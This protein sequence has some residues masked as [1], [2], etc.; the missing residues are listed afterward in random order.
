MLCWYI[1]HREKSRLLLSQIR[2]FD[3]AQLRR[4]Y[5]LRKRRLLAYAFEVW[6]SGSNFDVDDSRD[7]I[8]P[9][10]FT[11]NC[12]CNFCRNFQWYLTGTPTR[13]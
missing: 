13:L 10:K 11:K 7:I 5:S 9:C 8:V 6:N 2:T 3:H 1:E 4:S 12:T